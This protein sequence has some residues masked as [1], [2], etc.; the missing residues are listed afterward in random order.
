MQGQ[1]SKRR[2]W[3]TRKTSG[4]Q[5]GHCDNNQWNTS[6]SSFCHCYGHPCIWFSSTW[7]FFM[8]IVKAPNI[9]L[10]A[11]TMFFLLVHCFLYIFIFN[12]TN[13]I[14]L[15]KIC[16][17][18]SS[19]GHNTE[20]KWN[21]T[22]N[23]ATKAQQALTVFNI[24]LHLIDY[25][26]KWLFQ[27]VQTSYLQ[28]FTASTLLQ[29]TTALFD[30]DFFKV[31]VFTGASCSM[32]GDITHFKNFILAE[33]Q[34]SVIGK[35]GFQAREKV[36]LVL[37]IKCDQGKVNDIRLQDSLFIP[38]LPCPVL[39]PRHW[40]KQGIETARQDVTCAIYK[41][42]HANCFETTTN[43]SRQSDTMM[44]LKHLTFSQH[45]VQPS[46]KLSMLSLRWMM[47]PCLTNIFFN[48]TED[49]QSPWW[50]CLWS[51]RICCSGAH[52][53]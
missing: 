40:S 11:A 24:D 38:G 31:C 30:S 53:P 18:Q 45:Q 25:C 33:H 7:T 46:I 17:H 23:Q 10:W 50:S 3:E 14:T 9:E 36:R 26:S 16:I 41:T 32:S 34:V 47:L 48:S 21:R 6:E 15:N 51:I 52:E 13:N 49:S 20:F 12:A 35:K 22:S 8:L 28:C 37:N 1:E 42:S 2:A 43:I 29:T 5:R 27:K 44:Q 39:V 4:S 19:Y